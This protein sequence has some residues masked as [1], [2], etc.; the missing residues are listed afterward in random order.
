[1]VAI[2]IDLGTTNSCVAVMRQGKVQVIAN[3]E[4]KNTTPSVVLFNE[5][6]EKVAVGE[7]AKSE[8]L[9][10]PGKVVFEAK[11]LIGRNF[12]D[13]EVKEFR[14]VAP[15][16]ILASRKNTPFVKVASKEYS[17]Q[18]ISAFVLQKMKETAEDYLGQKVQQAVV[19]VPAY[20]N[21]DQ[22]QAT[23]DAGELAGLEVIRII[24]EPTAAALAY[25][26]DKKK[27]L[28]TIAVFDLGG[29]TFDISII[30]INEGVFE[31]KATNGDTFLGGANFDQKIIEW[32]MTDFEKEQGVNLSQDKLA[33]QRLKEVAENAKQKLSFLEDADPNQAV[34]DIS[35]PFIAV[36][37][38]GP[39]NLSKKLSRRKLEELTASLLE[40]LVRPCQNCLRDSKV[41][42][43]DEVILVGG[44]TRML[45]VRQ[46]VQEI[47]GKEPNKSINPD[48]A[49]AMG[50]AIQAAIL[51][52]EV[53]EDIV[54][55]D[56]TPLSLGIETLGGIYTKL[57]PR[58]T[59]IPT[60]NSQIFS[61]ATDGQTSVDISVFQ[62]ERELA[63]DN[64]F[65][66]TFQLTG[67]E[68]AP[69][70]LPQVEVTFDVDANGI[71]S[72]SAEDKKTG[73]KEEVTIK[74]TQGLS[75]EEKE[76]MIRESQENAE[77]DQ[78]RR[79]NIEK[80]N[81]AQGYLYNFEKQ[82]SEWKK[83][84]QFSAE[85]GQFQEFQKLYQV[86]KT[87][88]EETNYEQIKEQLK[89]VEEIVKLATE[90]DKKLGGISSKEKS[91]ET[92]SEKATTEEEKEKK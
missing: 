69:K 3:K 48:E 52:G 40:K 50:A 5:K 35:L 42:K 64:K 17:A 22:R 8:S 82:I 2:G 63:R 41:K 21:D 24:N 14:K 47:F 34:V 61:T 75:K 76:R 16:Q 83:N 7:T 9:K 79:E 32:L 89:N 67:I 20:F 58:N 11:R 70:G 30:E 27:D 51:S 55:L 49:V 91:A 1:M 25:G 81:Q 86:L 19:T 71:L 56:V 77:K 33:L 92:N 54:L 88:V 72:V 78:E 10:E 43:V 18:Q 13:S 57:I 26:I 90:L 31:V 59:T 46:K 45:G 15:F 6:G 29:G 87:A 4:G 39:K 12:A 68:P 85:D 73:K 37:Q 28:R 65:L 44:M 60:K 66:K 62:G 38:T 23:K 74:D 36:N 84:P 53:Q 80:L